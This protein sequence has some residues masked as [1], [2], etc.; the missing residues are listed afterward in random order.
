MAEPSYHEV[1]PGGIDI[2]RWPHKHPLP[3]S[4]IVA[5][6][7]G[8]RLQA[9]RWSRGPGEDFEVHSHSYNKI[10][11]CVQGEITFTFPDLNEQVTLNPGDR[12]VLPFDISHGATV[13]PEGS[14][15]LEAEA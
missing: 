1:L 12:L 11:F 3:E 10:L 4:E 15:C 8:R 6:F 9:K 13:G 5:F 7:E 2:I 14:A